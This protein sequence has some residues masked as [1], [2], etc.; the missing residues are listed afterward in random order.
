MTK[1]KSLVEKC[2]K[3][4]NNISRLDTIKNELYQKLNDYQQIIIYGAGV[5]TLPA[6]LQLLEY[7]EKKPVCIVDSD[8]NKWG[9]VICGVEVCSL[10]QAV[11]QHG[12]DALI[13]IAVRGNNFDKRKINEA[14]ESAGFENVIQCG[15]W[16]SYRE[17][18]QLEDYNMMSDRNEN[19][20]PLKIKELEQLEARLE[21]RK[22]ILELYS[23][24]KARLLPYDYVYDYCEMGYF[25]KDVF[26][27]GLY[28]YV[29]D[30]GAYRGDTWE[31]FQCANI[32][33]LEYHAFEMDPINVK[34]LINK[35]EGYSESAKQKLKIHACAVGSKEGYIKICADGSVGSY[36]DEKEGN[37]NV[38]CVQLDSELKDVP[39]SCIKMDIEGAEKEALRGA[40]KIIKKNRPALIISTYHKDEDLWLIPQMIDEIVEDYTGIIRREGLFEYLYIAFPKEKALIMREG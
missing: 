7:M 20:I 37:Q 12:K 5:I 27:L 19:V 10:E 9:R 17:V 36:I 39:V 34:Y 24:I 33:Y 31:E 1:V 22:S 35:Y 28:S 25:P 16:M 2:C 30:C 21:D 38:R 18:L 13:I 29:V 8:L 6:I 14:L 40:E 32:P 23:I 15:N 4:R 11:K 26:D 3:V